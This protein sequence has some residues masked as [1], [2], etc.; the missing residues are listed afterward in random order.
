M[1]LLTGPAGSGK[2]NILLNQF[3]EALR[4]GGEGIR[5]LT[6]TAT[7]AQHL[8]NEVAREGLVFHRNLIQTL[9][10]F[11]EERGGVALLAE[12]PVLYLLVEQ[13]ARRLRRPEFE[14]VVDTAGFCAALAR[15]IEEFASAGCDSA[16]LAECLP[17]TPLGAAFL[18]VYAEVD[19]ELEARGLELR[20]R[21]L[22]RVAAR[23]EREGTG[24]IRTVWLDGFHALP[25]PE[26]RVIGALGRH[27]EV[28]MALADSDLTPALRKRLEGMGFREERAPRRRPAPA[29]AVVKAAGIEREAEEIARRILEQAAGRPFREMGI[30]VRAAETYVPILRSTLERFGIPARFYFEQRLDRHAAVRYLSGA[31]DA[32]LGG[33]DHGETL[34]VLRLAPRFAD[35]NAMDR[36]DFAVREQTPNAGL[37]GLKALAEGSE[38]LLHRIDGLGEIE[39]WR[40]FALTPKDWAARFRTLRNLF[41]PARPEPDPER[42]EMWRSQAAALNEFDKALDDAACALETRH[43]A[44]LENFWRAVKAVLRLKPLRL[45][46]GR[47]NVVHVLSAPEAR[48]W[49]LPVVF[50]C[51][52][53]EKQFP[54]TH[55]QDVFFPETARAQLNA[56]GIRVRTVAEFDREERALF[57]SAITRATMLVTLSY[58]EFSPRGETNLRSL[59]LEECAA[60]VEEQTARPVKP[61]PRD[62]RGPGG[63]PREGIR[64]PELLQILREKSETVSPTRLESYWQCPFQYFGRSVLRLKAR[65]VRP[66][67]RL[68]FLTQ[69]IIVHAVLAQLYERPQDVEALFEEVFDSKVE[70][71]EISPGYHRAGRRHAKAC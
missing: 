7:L 56:A 69:G 51:G 31:V 27:C 55:P 33:W 18:E 64:A 6:P 9:N 29:L 1:R 40:S 24:G 20:A 46:D 26:L 23:M 34:K 17:D 59:F 71:E 21:R 10:A 4:A 66:E 36:F 44:P 39:E 47:R 45:N 15:T 49:V 52:M 35:F 67:K 13:A 3:R 25:D 22:E 8:Q 68:D 62:R 65:P 70:E 42:A 48:Q 41:R 16:R 38:P 54:Q 28:T 5:L 63:G 50:V 57:D 53:V 37:G 19:R 11:V 2:T 30:I 43:T 32:M 60:T 14:R 58:A 12:Q 61:Q